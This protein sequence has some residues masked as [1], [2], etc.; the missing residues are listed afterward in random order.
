MVANRLSTIGDKARKSG[1]RLSMH[2][3]SFV[4]LHQIDPD[5][6]ERSVE[7]F[8]YHVDIRKVHGLW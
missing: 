5:V 6:V 3:D 7:E 8:E 4:F 2:P 1:V